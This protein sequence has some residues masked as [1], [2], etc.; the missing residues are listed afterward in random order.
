MTHKIWIVLVWR[1]RLTRVHSASTSMVM[2]SPFGQQS[3][4]CNGH[5]VVG[6]LHCG[7]VWSTKSLIACVFTYEHVTRL[8]P[9]GCSVELRLQ[10]SFC[11][12]KNSSWDCLVGKVAY[13]IC[14]YWWTGHWVGTKW[15]FSRIKILTENGQRKGMPSI[16]SSMFT[17]NLSYLFCIRW[18]AMLILGL[19]GWKSHL[20]HVPLLMKRSPWKDPH[21]QPHVHMYI[22][23]PCVICT[24][25]PILEEHKWEL[26]RDTF[27]QMWCNSSHNFTTKRNELRY[28]CC[29]SQLYFIG[30]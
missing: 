28:H 10:W 22:F 30:H 19:S 3:L 17:T 12:Q 27:L 18:S 20:L 4:F 6:S 8:A 2:V 23:C 7:T 29:L 14:V 21:S 1:C 5:F 15:V 11:G 9:S 13:C 26:P 24:S 16:L 25:L